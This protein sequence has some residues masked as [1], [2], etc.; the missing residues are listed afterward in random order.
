MWGDQVSHG[1]GPGDSW[2]CLRP[3]AAAEVTEA[4]IVGAIINV[5]P[6]GF[7]DGFMW[8]VY[9]GKASRKTASFLACATGRMNYM[10]R[11]QKR[12]A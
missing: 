1:S 6:T 8:N 12:K 4:A 3:K 10:P 5:E 9:E 2:R 7:A 11:K